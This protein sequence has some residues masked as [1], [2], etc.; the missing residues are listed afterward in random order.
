MVRRRLQEVSL[1]VFG[2]SWHAHISLLYFGQSA[3]YLINDL[4]SLYGLSALEQKHI[5]GHFEQLTV[6]IWFHLPSKSTFGFSTFGWT[7]QISSHSLNWL[8]EISPAVRFMHLYGTYFFVTFI[9]IF[10][11]TFLNP[12]LFSSII[13][14]CCL[15]LM[16]ATYIFKTNTGSYLYVVW[17]NILQDVVG[18]IY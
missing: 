11:V 10:M 18:D 17:N 5:T 15:A 4:Y 12:E 3:L 16:L 6:N 7:M 2:L 8:H 9:H 13:L 1:Q 14:V